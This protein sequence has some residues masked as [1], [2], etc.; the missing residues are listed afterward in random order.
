MSEKLKGGL[1]GMRK[2]NN[3][4][5]HMVEEFKKTIF[6]MLQKCRCLYNYR[7]WNGLDNFLMYQPEDYELIGCV[8]DEN[9]LLDSDFFYKAFK[10][11]WNER[12]GSVTT[13][14]DEESFYTMLYRTGD[15]ISYG[16]NS[17][18]PLCTIS[19]GGNRKKQ[20]FCICKDSVGYSN[21]MLNWL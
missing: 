2:E 21:S 20:Y 10:H 12:Q 18:K 11:D 16:T 8:N 9:F 1:F 13:I 7:D 6:D 15:I 5:Q 4:F 17:D 3:L 19:M 14:P